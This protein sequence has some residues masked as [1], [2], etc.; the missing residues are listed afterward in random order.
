MNPDYRQMLAWL[1]A[2]PQIENLR[3]GVCD[4]NGQ[5]RG[6]LI[7]ATQAKKALTGGLRIPLSATSVDIWGNDIT[8]SKLVYQHGDRDGILEW[9]GRSILPMEWLG[10]P[11]GLISLWLRDEAG[12]PFAADPRRALAI[13]L[14]RYA[15]LGLQPV[16]A[17]ELE[18]Y[19]LDASQGRPVT[20]KSPVNGK[21]LAANAVLSID[22][23]DQFDAFFHD[24]YTACSE[25]GIPADTA[26]AEGGAGQFEINLLHCDDAMRA[27]DDALL[28]KRIVKG[29][30]RKHQMTASFMAKPYPERAGNGFHIHFSLL[31]R[32]GENVFDDGSDSGSITLRHA[33]AGLLDALVPTTLIFAPH[34]NSYRRLQPHTHAPSTVCWGYENRHAAIRIPGGS[35]EV[36]RIEHRVA[37]AD[38]NPYLV[39]AAILGAA[40]IGI[41]KKKLPDEPVVGDHFPATARQLPNDWNTAISAFEKSR[42]SALIFSPLLCNLFVSCKQQEYTVF[43]GQM[44][45]LEF[46]TYL[47]ST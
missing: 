21:P 17:A 42:I 3:A 18:F 23:L 6:K 40:L 16:V 10:Q 47:E 14:E 20:P 13:V 44:T 35:P 25:Q 22:E 41:E 39:L 26:I 43:A 1:D 29:M 34:L 46:S 31:D 38:A 28:F 5:M 7:P 2:R 8:G 33:V 45:D 36:R 37:G 12:S 30:A 4:L 32:A 27:A 15:E 11:S 19:L 9:T 24:V